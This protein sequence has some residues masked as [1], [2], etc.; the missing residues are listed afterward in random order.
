MNKKIIFQK[1]EIIYIFGWGISLINF[2][3]LL[4]KT[5]FTVYFIKEWMENCLIEENVSYYNLSD[6]GGKVHIYDQAVLN[7]LLYKYKVKSFKPGIKDENEFRN[8]DLE[9]RK[10][11]RSHCQSYQFYVKSMKNFINP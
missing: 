10:R 9:K 3:N 2:A 1:I 4:K 7:C 8:Y 11:D 5:N 6:I